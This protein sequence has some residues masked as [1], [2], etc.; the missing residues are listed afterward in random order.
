MYILS[1][2]PNKIFNIQLEHIIV[3][4][5]GINFFCTRIGHTGGTR[6]KMLIRFQYKLYLAFADA[7]SAIAHM[8]F[9][10]AKQALT[11]I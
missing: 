9:V 11:K 3:F 7:L 6:P 1:Y 4:I 10:Q 2:L 8:N 5:L